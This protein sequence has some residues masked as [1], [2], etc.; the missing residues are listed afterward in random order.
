MSEERAMW[1]EFIRIGEAVLRRQREESN[2]TPHRESSYLCS[3]ETLGERETCESE[4]FKCNRAARSAGGSH[5]TP[6][7]TE[8]QQTP[9]TPPASLIDAS[10]QLSQRQGA[11]PIFDHAEGTMELF[12][13]SGESVKIMLD[14]TLQS[15]ENNPMK[16]IVISVR[17]TKPE[18]QNIRRAAR[19]AEQ[20]LSFFSRECIL[21]E[22]RRAE[23][24][25][26]E[27]VKDEIIEGINRLLREMSEG[28]KSA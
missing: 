1:R 6:P 23:N 25:P 2:R 28:K 3:P 17:V 16:T 24:P 14:S 22:M 18:H 19:G 27:N 15:E 13:E 7:A 8:E 10:D 4:A 9:R 11:S 20:S 21:G 26:M 5:G 12:L